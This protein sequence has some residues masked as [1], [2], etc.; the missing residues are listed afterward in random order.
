MPVMGGV[1]TVPVWWV[2]PGF[3]HL[4]PV[5]SG[6]QFLAVCGRPMLREVLDYVFGVGYYS[7][8]GF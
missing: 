4:W 1:L 6:R 2:A 3:T 5:A 7:G 8:D